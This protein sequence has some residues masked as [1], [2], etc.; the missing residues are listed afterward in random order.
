[1]SGGYQ[2]QV[3]AALRWLDLIGENGEIKPILVGLATTPDQRPQVIGELLRTH[4]QSVFA[5]SNSNGTQCQLEEEF[6]KFGV[7][8]S[9]LRRAVAFFLHAARYAEIS[10]SPH[11]KI[12][13]APNNGKPS[14]RKRRADKGAASEEQQPTTLAERDP[15]SDLRTRYIEMLLDKAE[16][17]EQ[18]DSALLDRIETLLGYRERNE[19]GVRDPLL[20]V[21][22]APGGE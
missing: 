4:Y 12:P 17:Q 15:S 13:P 1:M 18:M 10:V 22:A 20:T 2:S 6:R 8:G 19:N 16:S 3:I 14:I 11:F 7:S 5:L 21:A 9:T